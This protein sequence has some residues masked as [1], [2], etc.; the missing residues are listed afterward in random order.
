MTIV[1]MVGSGGGDI[2]GTTEVITSTTPY[3]LIKGVFKITSAGAT[4]VTSTNGS[5]SSDVTYTKIDLTQPIVKNINDVGITERETP[6]TGEYANSTYKLTSY[7]ARWFGTSSVSSDTWYKWTGDEKVLYSG[8]QLYDYLSGTLPDG[9][10]IINTK[11]RLRF[12]NESSYN[13]YTTNH[14][15][16]ITYDRATTTFNCRLRITKNN[17]VVTIEASPVT[18]PS[19]DYLMAY[20]RYSTWQY[21]HMYILPES[22]A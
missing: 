21:F 6:A 17:G 1:N 11:I 20:V 13:Q 4:S 10:H 7:I 22:I 8:Y 9:E 2:E 18:I 16:T 15:D 3:V 14:L 5:Y 12:F 19:G